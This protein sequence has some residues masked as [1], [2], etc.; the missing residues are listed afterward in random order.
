[1]PSVLKDK[2][3]RGTVIFAGTRKQPQNKAALIA[4]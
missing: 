4:D 1:M 2:A 3:E